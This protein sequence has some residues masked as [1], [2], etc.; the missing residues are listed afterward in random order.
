LLEPPAQAGLVDDEA[1]LLEQFVDRCALEHLALAGDDT[2]VV[3]FQPAIAQGGDQCGA[4]GAHTLGLKIQLGQFGRLHAA[5]EGD[6]VGKLNMVGQ[7]PVAQAV[8]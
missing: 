3:V 5:P 4:L 1:P 2:Q 6:G 7:V 8:V